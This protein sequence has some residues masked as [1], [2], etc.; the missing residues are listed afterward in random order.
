MENMTGYLREGGDPNSGHRKGPRD[1]KFLK[2]W[3]KYDVKAYHYTKT[4]Q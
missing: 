1:L 2:K 4:N 3:V